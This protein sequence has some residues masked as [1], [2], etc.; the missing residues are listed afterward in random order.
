MAH[1][2]ALQAAGGGTIPKCQAARKALACAR[3][4]GASEKSERVEVAALLLLISS[5]NLVESE[6]DEAVKRLQE[7]Q[8]G[9]SGRKPAS[10]SVRRALFIAQ[11][12]PGLLTIAAK[13][14]LKSGLF[15]T[16]GATGPDKPRLSQ[17]RRA[18]TSAHTF[19]P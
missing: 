12:N 2:K 8:H 9:P 15:A 13:S 1:A 16:T 6:V 14:A 3:K 4:A 11:A 5:W 7:L 10:C 18:K 17:A 19:W